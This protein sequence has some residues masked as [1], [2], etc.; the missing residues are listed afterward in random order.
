MGKVLKARSPLRPL[1]GDRTTEYRISAMK[2]VYLD[3][4]W[5]R[6]SLH[7]TLFSHPPS[8][9]QFLTQTPRWEKTSRFMWKAGRSSPIIRNVIIR[10]VP[11]NLYKSYFERYRK[12]PEGTDLTYCTGRVSFRKERWVVDLEAVSQLA[13]SY[14]HHFERHKKTIEKL[15][16]SE[17]CKKILPPT[18]AA[19]NSLLQNL[20][21]EGY[22][23]KLEVIPWVTSKKSFAKEFADDRE[24]VKLLFVGSANIAGQFVVKGGQE[25]IEMF[26]LL[27]K[28]F[29]YLEL[30]I[31]SD[32][33]KTI[34][35]KYQGVENIKWIEQE[36]PREQ[37]QQEFKSADIYICPAH[38]TPAL[39]I[40]E[41]MS[42]ELPVIALDVWGTPENVQDGVTGFL[43][44]KSDKIPYYSEN[45]LPNWLDKAST[46]WKALNTVDHR[47]VQDL[48]AKTT[49]LIEN[50]ELRK[51][52]GKAGREVVETGY[53]SIE[54][55]NEKLKKVL[56]EAIMP[57]S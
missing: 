50:K 45:F 48:A 19:K 24:T 4:A 35:L 5:I 1:L 14:F 12:I 39:V 18:E 38:H 29:P 32:V 11:V 15:L 10:R 16:K 51:R 43:I 7:N 56:D 33:P 31:R 3:T 6:H 55:R 40:P 52:M 13:G 17:C 8:G 28:R 22:E 54:K 41:A 42:Y 23:H 44:K 26:I 21:F 25:V 34:R 53:L 2:T 27:R 36:I 49:V 20:D 37:L 57:V 47:V 30:V 46:F 9:Y